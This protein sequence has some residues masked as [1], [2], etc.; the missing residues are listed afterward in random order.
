MKSRYWLFIILLTLLIL[1]ACETGNGTPTPT[2]VPL[3][4]SAAARSQF[5]DAPPTATRL[6]YPSPTPTRTPLMISDLSLLS[7]TP[8]PTPTAP[9]KSST[10]QA[11]VMVSSLNIRQGPG[12]D[13]PIIGV[14]LVGDT[15]EIVGGSSSHWVQVITNDNTQG[16]ISGKPTYTRITG[17]LDD[18]PVVQASPPP[19]LASANTASTST[20]PDGK[21]I[22]MTR[23]GGDLYVINAN[24]TNLRHLAS[25]VI[26][27]IV[28]P[29]GS[30]VAFT[31]WDGA[32]MG[33]VYT[34]DLDTTKERI[35]LG[36]TLQ[37]KSPTWSPDG[38]DI[39]VS[40]QH[41]GLRNP[42]PTCRDFD[43]DDGINLPKNIRILKTRFDP[44]TGILTVC[45]IRLEDLQWKLRRVD[46]TTG[47]FEDLPVDLYSYNPAWDPQNPWRVIYDGSKGL[48][49]LDVTNGD[50]QP[51]TSDLRD[52][53][54]VFS[55]DGQ[56]LALTYKQHDHWEVYTLDLVSGTRQRLTKP[57]IL[58]DPQYSSASP[59]WLPDGRQIAFV[60]NRTGIWEIWGMNA[61]GSN[62]HPLFPPEVQAQLGLEYWGMNERMLNWVK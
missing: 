28:S 48:M 22:F 26:D 43:F 2:I 8:T 58:A 44:T 55:P 51:F 29:D 37:A 52:T 9:T 14:A 40:F 17:S 4:D 5:D 31:R 36:E 6:P 45:F 49:Q 38:Q 13:Y 10:T 1:T 53:G 19:V 7:S 16:W 42:Q 57:P 60:T 59:A 23:S 30:Q 21:L 54:P 15:F 24:G 39:I 32:E 46:L 47:E 27:P 50:Q 41:G 34:L 33:T 62:Q 61:D 56:T 18:M 25:G 3:D 12:I 20:G 35:V 11:E